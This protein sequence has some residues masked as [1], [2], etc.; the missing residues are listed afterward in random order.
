M[1]CYADSDTQIWMC[2][3]GV[4]GKGTYEGK[5]HV[6][7]A[8]NGAHKG[9]STYEDP[10]NA[11]SVLANKATDLSPLDQFSKNGHGF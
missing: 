9:T 8:L 6:Y 5:V 2:L 1:V 4:A 11:N 10:C 7:P 3:N